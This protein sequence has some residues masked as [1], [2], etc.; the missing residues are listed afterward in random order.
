MKGILIDD[1][2]R[3][4]SEPGNESI[5]LTSLKKDDEFE[6]GKVSR[7]NKQ[8]WVEVTLASGQKGYIKGETHIFEIKKVQ[9]INNE[10]EMRESASE[11]SAVLKTHPKNTVLTAVGFEKTD[12]NK[13]W[14]KVIDDEG[15][16]GFIKGD[17]RIKMYLEP[18]KAGGRKTMIS[19]GVF[20]LLGIAFYIYTTIQAQ[21][22]AAE[23]TGGNTSLITIAIVAFGLMQF[24]QGLM[25]Y[26]KAAK[27]EKE[28]AQSK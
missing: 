22:Q 17:A 10:N 26:L 24:A 19:G 3:V 7:K 23:Q 16:T 12:E 25:E 15:T 18:S 1:E 9:L 21:S 14:V 13:G 8:V 4:Y 28:K 20:A 6:L 11:E 2:V 5:S 27:K